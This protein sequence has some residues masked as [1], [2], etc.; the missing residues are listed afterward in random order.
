MRTTAKSDPKIN[1]TI[2]LIIC[3]FKANTG[4]HFY[5]FII[6]SADNIKKWAAFLQE[7]EL[8]Q[9]LL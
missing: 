4:N 8:M 7:E 3:S 5:V 1:I 6:A 9:D 2:Q